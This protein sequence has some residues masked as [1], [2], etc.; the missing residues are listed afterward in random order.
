MF[1]TEKGGKKE[2]KK[3]DKFMPHRQRG[4]GKKGG[5]SFYSAGRGGKKGRLRNYEEESRKGSSATW[6][7][8]REGKGRNRRALQVKEFLGQRRKEKRRSSLP[9]LGGEEKKRGIDALKENFSARLCASREE[10]EGRD[11]ISTSSI[12]GE[13]KERKTKHILPGTSE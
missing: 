2:E 8:G 7:L 12:K 11:S 1:I 5:S 9:S 10:K 6:K 3:R 13:R 4:G